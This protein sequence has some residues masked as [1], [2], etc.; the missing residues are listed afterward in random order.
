MKPRPKAT[1]GTTYELKCPCG[2]LY[3]TCNDIDGELFEVFAT[4]GKAGGCGAANK[5]AIG[6]L[7]SIALRGG[8]AP[9][10]LIKGMSGVTCHRSNAQM[11]SCISQMASILKE[12]EEAKTLNKKITTFST[13]DTITVG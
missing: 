5:A 2:D 7:L 12:H 3:V 13:T 6:I 8:V 1:K 11:E 9:E 4:L 10:Y